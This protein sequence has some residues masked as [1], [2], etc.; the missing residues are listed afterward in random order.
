MVAVDISDRLEADV[1]RLEDL[2]SSACLEAEADR[3]PDARSACLVPDDDLKEFLE[4][5]LE[6]RSSVCLTA[7]V[8]RR[9]EAAG[10]LEREALVEAM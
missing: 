3:V 5:F 8:E 10:T 7:V 4:E 6:E 9:G 1:D 2:E